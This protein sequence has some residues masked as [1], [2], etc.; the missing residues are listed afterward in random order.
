M[1]IEILNKNAVKL[2]Q[3]K[4]T[5][6]M[7]YTAYAV[8]YSCWMLLLKYTLCPFK[9]AFIRIKCCPVIIVHFYR[10]KNNKNNENLLSF[11]LQ[12]HL[13]MSIQNAKIDTHASS[14]HM[15]F[16]YVFFG[17]WLSFE[18]CIFVKK[19]KKVEIYCIQ[20]TLFYFLCVCWAYC[21]CFESK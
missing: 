21:I 2:A 16:V 18:K 15:Q 3:N 20:H 13:L 17:F 10:T 14:I 8:V 7:L 6:Y 12:L 11:L 1:R 4:Y 19:K 5:T 9:S